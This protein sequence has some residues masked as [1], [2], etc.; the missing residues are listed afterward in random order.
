MPEEPSASPSGAGGYPI[1][2]PGK[3]ELRNG[4]EKTLRKNWKI[5]FEFENESHLIT[6]EEISEG[7]ARLNVS[8]DSQAFDL[9]VNQ[10]R[11]LDLNNDGHND[12]RISLKDISDHEA[13]LLVM[14]MYREETACAPDW[15]CGDWRECAGGLQER[16]CTD[17]ND[18]NTS[19]GRPEES[20]SCC[21]PEW[22]CGD[23][24]ECAG[25]LQER[26]CRDL[27][28]CNTREGRPGVLRACEP[29]LS[30]GFW[31]IPA[32]VIIIALLIVFKNM[33]TKK[34]RKILSF[35]GFR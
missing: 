13:T 6:L 35:F 12:L 9:T 30:A 10:S 32:V 25:G 34:R 21:V 7:T 1:F 24:R 27:N 28:N 26:T 16:E 8:S 5:S 29:G 20:K 18:C 17:L 14:I 4:Y 33:K 2:A 11:E 22:E 3:Q 15:E 31:I 23:W 19:E